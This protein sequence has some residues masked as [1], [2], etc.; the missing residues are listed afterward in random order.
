MGRHWLVLSAS[1]YDEIFPL[2]ISLRLLCRKQSRDK[3]NQNQ[4]DQ[5]RSSSSFYIMHSSFLIITEYLNDFYWVKCVLGETVQYLSKLSKFL[6]ARILEWVAIPFSRGSSPPRDWTQVSCIGRQI[7]YCL[8]HQESLVWV[9]I[10]ELNCPA[11]GF[12]GGSVVKNFPVSAE[13]T[14][15]IPY[16]GRSYMLRGS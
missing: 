1:R 12:P 11:W 16:P 7:L 10:G 3:Q 14:S 4:D 13:D 15:A 2:R 9:R 8:S 6:Q 5:L